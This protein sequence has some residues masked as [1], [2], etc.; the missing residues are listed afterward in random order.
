MPAFLTPINFDQAWKKVATNQGCAGVDG[1]TIAHFALQAD[2][3][4]G[5][6]RKTIANWEYYPMPLRQIFIPK[7]DG[8]W[9]ELRVP[10]VR[11]RI[12]QQAT[13]NVLHPLLEKEFEPCSFAYRPGRSH[14][15]AAEQVSS[16][17]RRGY[18]WVLDGDIFDYFNNVKLNHLMAE[19]QERISTKVLGNA[20][21]AA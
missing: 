7:K 8:R 11:D 16:L 1:E 5:R 14:K 18:E 12:V 17:Y 9:R 3:Y 20:V 2:T 19:A 10:T 4:L 21:I 6:I 15:M 13:L